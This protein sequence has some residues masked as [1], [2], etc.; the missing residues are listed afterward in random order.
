MRQVSSLNKKKEKEMLLNHD[1]RLLKR[2]NEDN[3]VWVG[4]GSIMG[5]ILSCGKER[6]NYTPMG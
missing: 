3:K 2:T 6:A 1:E 5:S 4:E